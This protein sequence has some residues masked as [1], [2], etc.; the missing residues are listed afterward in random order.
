M[1]L[2]KFSRRSC[3]TLKNLCHDFSLG[4]VIRV[5]S[6][7]L[8]W[9]TNS[10]LRHKKWWSAVLLLARSRN[11]NDARAQ[12][13]TETYNSNK[14][15]S[16]ISS[17]WM[18]WFSNSWHFIFTTISLPQPV[19]F[20]AFCRLPPHSFFCLFCTFQFLFYIDFS[21]YDWNNNS[22]DATLSSTSQHHRADN[23]R[24]ASGIWENEDFYSSLAKAKLQKHQ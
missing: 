5:V 15:N 19:T 24:R 17:P 13:S 21:K 4:L 11:P 9:D 3:K 22:N 7:P 8:Q 23:S 18:R 14:W 10:K 6:R 16:H 1:E 2:S 12:S 20:R